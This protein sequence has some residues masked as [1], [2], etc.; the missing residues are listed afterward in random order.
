MKYMERFNHSH[1]GYKLD[2]EGIVRPDTAITIN[3]ED[4]KRVL[5]SRDEK[6][7]VQNEWM[8]EG[9][10]KFLDG[11]SLNG[12]RVGYVTYPR[13]GS[14]FSRKYFEEISGVTTGSD[15]ALELNFMF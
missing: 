7:M 15:M 13:M 1:P 14:T 8:F 2:Q 11:S 3:F 12:N 10:S 6:D 9:P 4:L 5:L